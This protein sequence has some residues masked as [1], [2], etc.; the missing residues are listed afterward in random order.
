MVTVTVKNEPTAPGN[1]PPL[2]PSLGPISEN[3]LKRTNYT[4]LIKSKFS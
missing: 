1:Y 2:P 3:L 4:P